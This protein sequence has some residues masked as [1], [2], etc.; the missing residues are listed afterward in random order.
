MGRGHC[1]IDLHLLRQMP[2]AL[3]PRFPVAGHNTVEKP[4]REA[5]TGRVYIN[6]TQYFN[7]VPQATW[8]FK[9]G[10][11]QVCEK[12]LKDRKGRTLTLEDVEHYQNTVAALTHTRV[13]VQIDALATAVLW[14]GLTS[15]G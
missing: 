7:G 9:V 4:R 10:G 11:Y 6:A 13:M 15:T 1:M 14:P 3:R 8:E 2:P 5:A 12:W